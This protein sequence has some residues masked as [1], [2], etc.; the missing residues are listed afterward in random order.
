[1]SE[2]LEEMKDLVDSTKINE[3]KKEIKDLQKAKAKFEKAKEK[4]ANFALPFL[5]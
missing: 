4:K 5:P 1:M 3:L 2:S